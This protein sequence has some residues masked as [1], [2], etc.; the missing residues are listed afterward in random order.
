MARDRKPDGLAKQPLEACL[1]VAERRN[2]QRPNLEAGYN[3]GHLGAPSKVRG[4]LLTSPPLD[5]SV[6]CVVGRYNNRQHM[7]P[8]CVG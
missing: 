8:A 3:N 1:D 4:Q 7:Q 5:P 2:G 6:P